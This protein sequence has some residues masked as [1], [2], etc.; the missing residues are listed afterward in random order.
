MG[1]L[2][3][4]YS[5]AIRPLCVP[6]VRGALWLVTGAGCAYR[7]VMDI[8][9]SPGA[10]LQWRCP[11]A[12]ELQVCAGRLWLTVSGDARDR[13]LGAG[14]QVCLPARCEA[15]LGAE[16]SEPLRLRGRLARPTGI[17]V[18]AYRRRAARQREV[19]RRWWWRGLRRRLQRW[20]F[21]GPRPG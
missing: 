4:R 20:L 9:L 7:A 10:H 17:D 3:G 8:T 5:R 16:G 12:I 2:A 6:V 14:E 13:F 11:R 15:V 1:A 21:S 18:P 19:A